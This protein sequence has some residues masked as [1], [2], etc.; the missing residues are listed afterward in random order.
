MLRE[1][2]CY[3]RKYATGDVAR[4]IPKLLGAIGLGDAHRR[5]LS[6]IER[7]DGQLRRSD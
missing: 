6:L 3:G 2:I 5:A 1:E 4:S 7:S